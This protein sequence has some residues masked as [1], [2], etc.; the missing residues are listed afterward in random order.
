MKLYHIEQSL[1]LH[2]EKFWGH[3]PCRN[4]DVSRIRRKPNG[5]TPRSGASATSFFT[6]VFYFGL[7]LLEISSFSCISV[8][9]IFKGVSVVYPF[10]KVSRGQARARPD[11]CR[12][13]RARA[14]P[15]DFFSKQGTPHPPLT[16]ERQAHFYPI[17]GN[18]L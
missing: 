6:P 14:R 11:D 10:P 17:K 16:R 1:I 4:V 5:K 7:F 15:H 13:G 8:H 9:F 3:H 2:Y 18:L 12:G